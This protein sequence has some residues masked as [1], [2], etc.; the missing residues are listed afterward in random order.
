VEVPA[1]LLAV[2]LGCTGIENN[3]Y[4]GLKEC[5]RA[6]MDQAMR[7][8]VSFVCGGENIQLRIGV[9]EHIPATG[10]RPFDIGI[11]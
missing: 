10:V 4:I 9:P 11:V 7:F 1:K 6:A 3:K 8:F 2:A 5:Y